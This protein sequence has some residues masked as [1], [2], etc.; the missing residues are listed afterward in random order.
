MKRWRKVRVEGEGEAKRESKRKP[1]RALRKLPACQK[2][3]RGRRWIMAGR[4]DIGDYRGATQMADS[5]I[6]HYD[7]TCRAMPCHAMC[8]NSL[9]RG[10][11]WA[12]VRTG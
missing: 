11:L 7:M 1:L 2:N 10:L 6:H 12:A 8:R 3:A 5:A 9:V 4:Q